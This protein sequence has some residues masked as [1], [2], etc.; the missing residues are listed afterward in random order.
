MVIVRERE[1]F[2]D[3]GRQSGLWLSLRPSPR[4]PRTVCAQEFFS[5]PTVYVCFTEVILQIRQGKRKATLAIAEKCY[6]NMLAF[7][8]LVRSDLHVCNVPFQL[9]R[10]PPL[11]YVKRSMI[12]QTF[13]LF[14]MLELSDGNRDC[15]IT[16]WPALS[17]QW[18]AGVGICVM[19][20]SRMTG[21]KH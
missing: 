5:T 3:V 1:V 14:Y 10:W 2:V 17:R 13:K 16:T 19:P 21:W 20:P 11:R 8:V 6:S 12:R 4:N 7:L 18:Y 9:I 15:A